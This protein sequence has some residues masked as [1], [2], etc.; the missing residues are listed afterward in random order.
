MRARPAKTS[1]AKTALA[2]AAAASAA[3]TAPR[4]PASRR[5][6]ATPDGANEPGKRINDENRAS[7]AVSG[8]GSDIRRQTL[9]SISKRR[10]LTSGDASSGRSRASRRHRAQAPRPRRS[11]SLRVT[12]VRG[13]TVR[14]LHGDVDDD[15]YDYDHEHDYDYDDDDH[16][17]R[18]RAFLMSDAS[19][20]SASV[21]FTVSSRK[22]RSAA[23][24]DDSHEAPFSDCHRHPDP[25]R[26]TRPR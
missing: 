4:F 13:R 7:E 24:D 17:G 3:A 11:I 16:R 15:D 22:Q 25:D 23:R 6:E 10:T 19:L 21:L 12:S 1:F 26:G 14:A 2:A 20:L 5:A 8:L 9:L 18:P